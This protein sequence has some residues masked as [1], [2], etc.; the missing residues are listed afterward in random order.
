MESVSMARNYG[1]WD[2]EDGRA[3]KTNGKWVDLTG[4]ISEQFP[5]GDTIVPSSISPAFS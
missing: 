2:V 3:F 5:S 1:R 4:L